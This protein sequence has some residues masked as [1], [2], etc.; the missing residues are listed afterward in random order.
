MAEKKMATRAA[1]GAALEELGGKYPNIIALDA[2][3]SCCT[4]SK[5]F[6]QA[7]PERFFNIGIA[8]ANMVGIAA[9]LAT[10]G[11]TVFVHSFAMF[12]AGRAYDQVRNSVCYPNLNVKVVGTHAGL[13]VGED[14]ATHQCIEDISIMRTIPNMVV[15]HP[16]DANETKCAAE[17]IAAHYG[18]CYLRLGRS[19]VEEVTDYDGYRFELGKG[20]TMRSGRDVTLVATGLMVHE[21]LQAAQLLAKEGI[22]ARVVDMHT[23]KPIDRELLIACAEETGAIVTAEEHNVIGGLGAA[24]CEAIADACPVPVI[25]VGINDCFGRSGKASV[26]L[27]MYH[28]R[29]EDICSAAHKA[30]ALKR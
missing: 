30:I 14:G 6:A 17:A 29:A 22:D 10:T 19:E 12:A 28:L 8:E 3:L 4:M 23:I 13:T 16:C 1:Y 20:V 25:R 9:G 2:D 15:V 5:H 7:Y 11:K 27:D 24:V 26:L 18:P 21:A